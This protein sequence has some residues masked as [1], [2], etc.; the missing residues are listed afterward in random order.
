MTEK[1]LEYSI[2]LIIINTVVYLGFYI[3]IAFIK[4]IKFTLKRQK[5]VYR[6][7]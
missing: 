7:K 4:T 2:M 5:N 1:I 6:G 3:I